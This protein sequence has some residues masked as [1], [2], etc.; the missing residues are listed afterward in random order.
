[1]KNLAFVGVLL[2]VLGL[3]SL[4]SYQFLTARITA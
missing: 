2:L 4:S 3:L 1:M